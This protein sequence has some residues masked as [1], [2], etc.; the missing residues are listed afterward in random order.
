M[1]NLLLESLGSEPVTGWLVAVEGQ[2]YGEDFRL[3]NGRN[4]I[5]RSSEMDVQLTLD[6]TVSRR[7]H[8]I[9]EYNSEEKQFYAEPGESRELVYLNDEL[10]LD[11]T[12]IKSY[13]I[14]TLGKTKLMMVALCGER[15][16]WPNPS[17]G[18]NENHPLY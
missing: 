7:N 12:P 4:Q 11:T 1:N 17:G 14:L 18:S 10:V 8:A 16:T 9:I 3:K 2:Y 15:F 6:L 5:G 13:D